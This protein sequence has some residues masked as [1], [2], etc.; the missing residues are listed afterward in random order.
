MLEAQPTLRCPRCD[1]PCVQWTQPQKLH[2]YLL[3]LMALSA[4]QCQAC[5]CRFMVDQSGVWPPSAA[6]DRRHGNHRV[7]SPPATCAG[8]QDAGQGLAT[9][10]S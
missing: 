9:E 3:S 1:S 5:A 2:E 8:E 6:I 10:H 7:T 4:R